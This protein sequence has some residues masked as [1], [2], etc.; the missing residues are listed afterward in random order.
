MTRRALSRVLPFVLLALS[1]CSIAPPP[2]D[3]VA[4]DFGP[5]API[6]GKSRLVLNLN[7]AEVIAPG[8]MNNAN[9]HYRLA[10]I[11][12]ARPLPYANSRWVMPPAA[13]FT[14]RLRST[15]QQ[16]SGAAVVSP[17]DG[18]NAEYAL[19]VDLEE[20]SQVFDSVEKSRGVMRLRARLA[21]GR[22]V[23]AQQTF[24]IEVPAPGA[25]AEGGVRALSLASDEACRMLIDWLT[26]KLRR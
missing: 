11:N 19:H 14:Q 12:A 9:L 3:I 13:L 4:Y 24:S 23:A 16:A 5:V 17:A 1:A 18:V 2:R 22:S 7:V 26:I 20:F 8:W 25:N 15:L 21:K 10:Y 6:A